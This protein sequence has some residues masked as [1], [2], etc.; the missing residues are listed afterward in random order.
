MYTM[1]RD[2]YLQT[3]GVSR[4]NNGSWQ[5]NGAALDLTAGYKVAVSDFLLTGKE[6]NLSFLN[7]DN[8]DLAV[9]EG[10]NKHEIRQVVIDYLEK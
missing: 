7:S 2:G 8:P 4:S 5:V 9:I 6:R 10:D 1:K 3:S